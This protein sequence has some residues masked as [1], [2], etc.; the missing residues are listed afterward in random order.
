MEIGYTKDRLALWLHG[1]E[2]V[3]IAAGTMI[4]LNL[5]SRQSPKSMLALIIIEAI[6]VVYYVI[7]A[8]AIAIKK[9]KQEY[10]V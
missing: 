8:I 9:E 7:K 5:F 10:K 3:G 4:L 6:I 2:I 1:T